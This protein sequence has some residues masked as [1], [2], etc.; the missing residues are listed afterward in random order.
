MIIERSPKTLRDT[1]RG[2]KRLG[3]LSASTAWQEPDDLNGT[4]F[5]RTAF[6]REL[7]ARKNWPFHEP[8]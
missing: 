4:W 1:L 8:S 3:L 6:L 2:M 7:A 5:I